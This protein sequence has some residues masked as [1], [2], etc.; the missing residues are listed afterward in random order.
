MKQFKKIV[1]LLRYALILPWVCWKD[2]AFRM[3]LDRWQKIHHLTGSRSVVLAE[4][5]WTKQEFR[6][7]F[8]YRNRFRRVYRT[9]VK[10]IYRP[11]NT[12]YIESKEIGGGLYIQH[13]FATMIAAE[14]I[15]TNCWINQQVTIGFN[16][17]GRPPIIGNDVMITCGAK[18][19]GSITVGDH[20]VIGAN[21]VVIR[22][23]EQDAVMGG[24][25]AKR[26]K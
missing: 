24:I 11:M 18:V 1:V 20:S 8:L 5:L 17:H 10:M 21:A 14:S 9:W 7:L 15:G 19:L 13:G 12:L 3:D 16:G 4:L 6:N 2:E 23:V 22:D 26:I 25:P